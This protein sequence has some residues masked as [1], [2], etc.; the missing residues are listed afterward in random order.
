MRFEKL[1]KTV[2]LIGIPV[3]VAVVGGILYITYHFIMKFW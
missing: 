3:Y 1:V 2:L